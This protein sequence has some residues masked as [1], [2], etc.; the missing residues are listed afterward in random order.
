M[1]SRHEKSSVEITRDNNFSLF[2]YNA[3]RLFCFIASSMMLSFACNSF[4][5]Y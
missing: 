4:L 2:A 1:H 3:A 5:Q